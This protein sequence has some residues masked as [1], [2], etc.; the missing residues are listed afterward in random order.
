ME[1]KQQTPNVQRP[2]SNAELPRPVFQIGETVYS[3]IAPDERGIVLAITQS[4]NGYTYDVA[5]A[6][7]HDKTSQHFAIELSRDAVY[8]V[9]TR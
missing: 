5:W 9:P 8:Q 4:P 6:A 2:T 3:A 7:A 1:G